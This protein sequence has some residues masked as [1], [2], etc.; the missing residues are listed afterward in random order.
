VVSWNA[1]L[2][3]KMALELLQEYHGLV[4]PS[5]SLCSLFLLFFFLF[6]PRSWPFSGF[7]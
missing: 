1:L 3:L 5:V 4:S 2:L 6:P 7:L